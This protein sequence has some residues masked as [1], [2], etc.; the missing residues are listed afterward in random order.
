MCYDESRAY[1]NKVDLQYTSDYLQTLIHK[2]EE[3]FKTLRDSHGKF[4]RTT[5]HDLIRHQ[6]QLSSN[7]TLSNITQIDAAAISLNRRDI[8]VLAGVTE[9][10][11]ALRLSMTKA[12]E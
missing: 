9:V 3:S 11:I 2:C 6:L 12:D 7:N 5:A 1:A 8:R 4:E 10:K